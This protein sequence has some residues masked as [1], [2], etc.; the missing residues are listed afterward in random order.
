M[1]KKK[2]LPAV[3]C[4]SILLTISTVNVQA[5]SISFKTLDGENRFYTSASI[6]Q[7]YNYTKSID[8][9][10]LAFGN[11]FPDA[12]SGSMISNKYKAPIL[13]CGKTESETSTALNFIKSNLS[14]SKTVYILGGTGGIKLDVENSL[15][16]YGYTVKRISGEDR[17]DTNIKVVDEL[18]PSK[19]TPVVIASGDNFPDALSISSA[20]ASKEYPLML[21]SKDSLTEAAKRKLL[22]INPSKLYVIGGIASISEKNLNQMKN[23]LNL[24]S[25]DVIRLAGENRYETSLKIA[26]FFN[27]NSDTA[28]IA[29][30]ENFPDAL[31]GSALAALKSSPII[32]VNNEDVSRQKTFI[33]NSSCSNLIFLGGEYSV[34]SK[35]KNA[36]TQND[37]NNENYSVD[38]KPVTSTFSSYKI[39][40]ESGVSENLINT[41]WD[42]YTIGDK[43]IRNP[44]FNKDNSNKINKNSVAFK[45][46]GQ[47]ITDCTPIQFF[48]ENGDFKILQHSSDKKLSVESFNKIISNSERGNLV[49]KQV[50]EVL[51]GFIKN[52][53]GNNT[54]ISLE[55]D[56]Y[57][58]DAD[59]TN[60]LGPSIN[61]STNNNLDYSMI[62]VRDDL[63]SKEKFKFRNAFPECDTFL[64]LYNLTNSKT[65]M[66][67]ILNSDKSFNL[68]DFDNS[69]LQ[70]LRVTLASTF[71]IEHSDKILNFITNEITN[72]NFS[73]G[74]VHRGPFNPY[75]FD[76]DN[77]TIYFDESN[78]VLGFKYNK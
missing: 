70:N 63:K 59:G 75:K 4:I 11:D 24:S 77:L 43:I 61:V 71:G 2:L 8:A 27:L 29:N 45:D 32:L 17:F 55:A 53:Y 23:L 76:L 49:S 58:P 67:N 41:T 73:K 47:A 52:A 64:W 74:A 1:I 68:D 66:L 54:K 16:S 37:S 33:D 3:T 25:S 46:F 13:L 56:G 18:N 31:S 21:T 22:E 9:V 15:K 48:T 20:A 26:E 28:V 69:K 10:I 72:N 14:S 6:A 42:E 40:P 62:F 65:S 60:C 12:L 51:N 35:T 57:V 36:L 30:G 34:N 39:S 44:Y 50:Y 38:L 78:F 19:G 7:E 5:K